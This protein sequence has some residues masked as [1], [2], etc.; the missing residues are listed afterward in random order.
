[1]KK[2][3][4]RIT[5]HRETLRSWETERLQQVAAAVNTVTV[6]EDESCTCTLKRTCSCIS[7]CC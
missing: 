2:K 6:C 7:T 5:L 3:P 4:P 1:M